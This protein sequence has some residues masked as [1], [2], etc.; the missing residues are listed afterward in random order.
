MGQ[1]I[2]HENLVV[3]RISYFMVRVTVRWEQVMPLSCQ[4]NIL[5]DYGFMALSL[6][7]DRG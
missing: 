2:N 7:V 1:G 6:I 4:C 5:R 3:I